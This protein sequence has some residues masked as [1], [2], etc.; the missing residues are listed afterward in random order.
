MDGFRFHYNRHRP[1]QGIGDITPAERYGIAPIPDGLI[2]LPEAAQLT[3]PD[4]PPGSFVRRVGSSGNIGFRGKLIQVGSRYTG[5]F[6]RVIEQ[7]RLTH[8][9][10]G[11]ALI[12]ALSIDPDR[13]Y[14][15]KPGK[16]PPTRR[17]NVT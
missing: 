8:I 11:D 9:Y 16:E 10:H 17:R 13:Y 15:P 12:R 3:E 14:Q 1:H 6:V 7:D 5:A 2:R 4:Y